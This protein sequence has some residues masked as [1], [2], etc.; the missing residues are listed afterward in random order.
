MNLVR[1]SLNFQFAV[2]AVIA[3]SAIL[4]ATCDRNVGD[5]AAETPSPVAGAPTQSPT[6]SPAPSPTP[7][8]TATPTPAPLSGA[9][10]FSRVSPSV[11]IVIT[12]SGLGSGVLIPG[13]FIVTNAHVVW[14]Y[15]NVL[16]KFPNSDAHRTLPVIGLDLMADLAVIGPV[17]V[18]EEGLA[19]KDGENLAIGSDV[20]LVGYPDEVE[21]FPDKP[22]ISRGVI[23]RFRQWRAL[24]LTLIQSDAAT[25]GGQSGGVMVSENG[26]VIGIT[27]RTFGDGRFIIAT[28]AADILERVDSLTRGED[29]DGLRDRRLPSHGATEQKFTLTDRWHSRVAVLYEREETEIE[30]RLEGEADSAFAVADVSGDLI[31]DIDDTESGVEWGT[32]TID[33]FGPHFVRF[34]QFSSE[35]GEFVLETS[36]DLA[37]IDDKDDH[38]RVSVE[39]SVVGNVDAPFDED[40]FELQLDAGESVTIRAESFMIDPYVRVARADWATAAV[41]DDD[42]GGGVLGRDA[43]V[44]FTAQESGTYIVLVSD[45]WDT[46]VGGYFLRIDWGA[47]PGCFADSRRNPGASTGREPPRPYVHLRQ[48]RVRLLHSVPDRLAGIPPEER[49]GRCRVT[50]SK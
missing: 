42:G 11:P 31:L 35:P 23:S 19:L 37:F 7:L 48:R 3:L 17:N 32:A 22:T 41:F 40:Y 50:I 10:I 44:S 13:G 1:R 14:G 18:L 21:V 16:V 8:P 28:S 27:T 12:G 6:A 30:I 43:F 2:A 15:P 29:V 46:H 4:G 39:E 5:S 26:D 9:E 20:Y 49:L 36:H 24:D 47:P 45:S 25:G 34:D 33:T 38:R